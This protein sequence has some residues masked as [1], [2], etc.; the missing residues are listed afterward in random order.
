MQPGLQPL[1]SMPAM[2]SIPRGTLMQ[3][4]EGHNWN[5][6]SGQWPTST[7][8]G[9]GYRTGDQWGPGLNGDGRRSIY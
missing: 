3:R 1:G 7:G 9:P 8:T 5:N 2:Q 6:N 4:F